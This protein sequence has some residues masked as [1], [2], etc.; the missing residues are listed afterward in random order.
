MEDWIRRE[1]RCKQ[2]STHYECVTHFACCPGVQTRTSVGKN[3]SYI[4]KIVHLCKMLE[5][6]SNLAIELAL[7]VN[8]PETFD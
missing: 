8:P 5:Q 6:R 7:L 1:A 4:V 2:V 3:G